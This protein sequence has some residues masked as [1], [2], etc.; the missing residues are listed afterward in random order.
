MWD[1]DRLHVIGRQNGQERQLQLSGNSA[2][3]SKRVHSL[4]ASFLLPDVESTV[5]HFNLHVYIYMLVDTIVYMRKHAVF[6]DAWIFLLACLSH[7]GTCDRI[8]GRSSIVSWLGFFCMF[9]IE[10]AGSFTEIVGRKCRE[11]EETWEVG[12][13]LLRHE[14]TVTHADSGLFATKSSVYLRD[15]CTAM[16]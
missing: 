2:D 13:V 6:I 11:F 16:T 9:F 7:S 12:G 3:V 4:L 10:M 5:G 14:A 1:V 15:L 8:V